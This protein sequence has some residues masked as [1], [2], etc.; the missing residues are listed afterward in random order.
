MWNTS[1][2]DCQCDKACKVGEYLA[3]KNCPYKKNI[4][5]KFVMPCE[6]DIKYNRGEIKCW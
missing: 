5:N 3:S 2:C 6:Y 1:T 4:F